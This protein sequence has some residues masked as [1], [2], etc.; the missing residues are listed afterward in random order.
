[1]NIPILFNIT[2][3]CKALHSYPSI[4]I[5]R[6]TVSDSIKLMISSSFVDFSGGWNWIRIDNR[7]LLCGHCTEQCHELS[8]YNSC[9]NIQVVNLLFGIHRNSSSTTFT[10]RMWIQCLI[11]ITE[12]ILN[13]LIWYYR[14]MLL[15][16]FDLTICLLKVSW[17]WVWF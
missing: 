7:I 3:G 16:N 9:H 12:Q 14:V 6:I 10:F 1:M 13:I 8:T 2:F 5:L 11:F 4:S 15:K 17:S